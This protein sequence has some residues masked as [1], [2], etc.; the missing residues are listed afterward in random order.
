MRELGGE[1]QQKIEAERAYL[2]EIGL[3]GICARS[4]MSKMLTFIP[5]GAGI[6]HANRQLQ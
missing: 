5:A 1:G 3:D 6:Y 4:T 2:K